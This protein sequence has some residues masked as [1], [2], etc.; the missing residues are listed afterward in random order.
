MFR[1]RLQRVIETT[2]KT[3][4]HAKGAISESRLIARPIA[5]PQ[6]HYSAP[7]RIAVNKNNILPQPI[8]AP[9]FSSL[10]LFSAAL[11]KP[12]HPNIIWATKQLAQLD[13]RFKLL[14]L[15]SD[16]AGTL[17]NKYC[18]LPFIIFAHLF[19]KMGYDLSHDQ[20]TGP[21]GLKK[22]EHI[23]HLLKELGIYTEKL[24]I[25]INAEFEKLLL[26]KIAEPAY[27]ELTPYTSDVIHF[28][29]ALSIKLCTTSGYVRKAAD[30]AMTQFLRLHQVD[31]STT[32]DEVATG[33]R[34]DMIIANMQKLQIPL[35]QM[36]KTVF[37]TD[38]QSD[39]TSALSPHNPE[40][41]P[42]V[43]GIRAYSTHVGIVSNEHGNNIQPEELEL[44]RQKAAANLEKAHLVI[45]DMSEVPLAM[46]TI[47]I[48]IENGVRPS[49][50]KKLQL[51]RPGD[52]IPLN[53]IKR[54]SCG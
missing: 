15:N 2:L 7:T 34:I 9:S 49:Q 35:E 23:R 37:I 5:L 14:A 12:M 28:L 41:T 48:A 47:Q 4:P 45:N 52:E 13:P 44:K 21:M 54:M 46:L 6:H 18:T 19:Q 26:E 30:L 53:N 38:A 3:L 32:S 24:A 17:V 42:W 51:L 43:V 10:R 29:N 8:S 25:E 20:I 27:T 40:H 16:I 11:Q 1:N 39:I 31:A 22:I 33:K 50:T 36:Y